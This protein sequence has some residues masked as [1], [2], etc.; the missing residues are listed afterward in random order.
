MDN[1]F[2]R[3]TTAWTPHRKVR[4]SKAHRFSPSYAV[5]KGLIR[6]PN[7]PPV[8]FPAEGNAAM[9]RYRRI[10]CELSV[11]I[12]GQSHVVKGDLS[13][14]GAMF[15]LPLRQETRTVTVSFRDARA[16][17]EVLATTKKDGQVAHH[18]RFVDLR[19]GQAVWAELIRS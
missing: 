19:E 12:D 1:A 17:A 4:N 14:G 5:H 18:A 3:A 9:R 16:V 11:T 2:Q 10:V 15:L 6:D 8:E 13:K 7:W